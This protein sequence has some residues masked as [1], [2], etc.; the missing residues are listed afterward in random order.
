MVSNSFQK[1]KF[2]FELWAELSVKDPQA[3]EELRQ[4][5]VD[6]FIGSVA[7]ERQER[8][9]CLQWKV[10]RVRETQKTPLAACVAI[11]DMMWDSLERLNQL[12]N[13]YE[14]VTSVKSGKRVLTPLPSAS[15]IPFGAR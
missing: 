2:N 7:E 6:E 10:D 15:V 14:S 9:R 4:Q 8:L 13:D 3:F 11:S 12:Y 5:T 1:E